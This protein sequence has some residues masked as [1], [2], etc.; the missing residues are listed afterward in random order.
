M[1]TKYSLINVFYEK[2]ALRKNDGKTESKKEAS[3]TIPTQFYQYEL[4]KCT[5]AGL[6]S[7][8]KNVFVKIP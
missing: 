3:E 2:V 7:N 5:K 4:S 1:V 6:D 8:E